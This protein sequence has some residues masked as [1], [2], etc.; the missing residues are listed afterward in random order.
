M[1]LSQITPK[2]AHFTVSSG[3]ESCRTKQTAMQSE[4]AVDVLDRTAETLFG[5]TLDILKYTINAP[6]V[7]PSIA[8]LIEKNAM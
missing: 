5:L 1:A 2:V 3:E 6:P 8:I 7:N 4:N